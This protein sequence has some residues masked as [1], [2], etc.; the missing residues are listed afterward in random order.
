[1]RVQTLDVATT[2]IRDTDVQ[3]LR[4]SFR[5]RLI[6]PSDPQFDEARRVWNGTID[7]RPA[8]IAQCS[9]A[10]DV[11]TAV[12][13]AAHHGLLVAV[14]GGGHSIPGHS[15][16][17]GGLVID[18]S[19]MRGVEVDPRR[20][21]VRAQGGALWGDVDHESQAFGLATPGGVVS[22]TGIAGL[23][24]GGGSQTWLIRKYGSSADSLVSADVVTANGD[25]LTASEKENDDLF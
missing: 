9:G 5:G 10:A 22:T 19:A 18:L 23:T 17:D 1:M 12:K 7:R 24:L 4:T 11:S 13:F 14:R 16:C 15:V 2:D 3:A 8:L 20:G 25:F 6:L 21:T